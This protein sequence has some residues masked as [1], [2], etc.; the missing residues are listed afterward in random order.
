MDSEE[1]KKSQAMLELFYLAKDHQALLQASQDQTLDPSVRSYA[2][3][4]LL[5]PWLPWGIKRKVLMFFI[6]G[7][8]TF[9]GITFQHASV[10]FLLVV[11]LC[12]S[13]RV[14][15]EV[16]IFVGKLSRGRRSQYH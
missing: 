8:I 1:F 14:V 15:G 16:S 6:A 12:F 5:R 10:L 11:P 9:F 4:L 7:L 3:G 2:S 13:P